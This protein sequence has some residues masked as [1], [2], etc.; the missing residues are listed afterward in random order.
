MRSAPFVLLPVAVSL[1]ACSSSSTEPA[2][3]SALA[4]SATA[5]H[6]GLAA[7]L[8][9]APGVVAAGSEFTIQYTVANTARDTARLV[10]GCAAPAGAMG[11]RGASQVTLLYLRQSGCYTMISTVVLPPGAERTVEFTWPATYESP[12]GGVGAPLPP[13]RYVLDVQSAL[14]ELNGQRTALPWLSA[15]FTVR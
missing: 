1:I 13:G 11:L 7:T 15:A 12:T 6:A 5:A 10:F 8:T 9:I 3:T 4:A 14:R 2:V